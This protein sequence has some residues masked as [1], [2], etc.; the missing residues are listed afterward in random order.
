MRRGNPEV[1]SLLASTMFRPGLQVDLR[2]DCLRSATVVPGEQLIG[3]LT[4]GGEIGPVFGYAYPEGTNHT[5]SAATIARHRCKDFHFRRSA[6]T[7]ATPQP[8]ERPWDA[9][10]IHSCTARRYAGP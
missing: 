7:G 5:D 1:D 9:S 8:G 6:F 4:E 3:R 10:R 2:N